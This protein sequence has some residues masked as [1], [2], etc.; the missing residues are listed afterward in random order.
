MIEL[1]FVIVIIGILAAVAIPKLAA[2]KDD[3]VASTCVHEVGQFT[4]EYS[5]AYAA[6]PDYKTWSTKYTIDDNI[7]NI[8]VGVKEGNGFTNVA[9]TLAH[10]IPLTYMCDG[11]TTP[12]VTIQ[13]NLDATTGAY[14]LTST[15]ATTNTSPAAVKAAKTLLKNQNNKTVKKFRL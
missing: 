1:I 10:N 13:G 12:I 6:A 11:D 3:A 2:N 4:S 7:T 14:V 9:G 15:V 8:N 5:Q